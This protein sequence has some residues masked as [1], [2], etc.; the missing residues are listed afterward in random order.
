MAIESFLLSA[1]SGGWAAFA[2]ESIGLLVLAIAHP[3]YAS[4]PFFSILHR[5]AKNGAP[6]CW[7]RKTC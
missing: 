6:N 3:H 7:E 5:C 4:V 2:W 1:L